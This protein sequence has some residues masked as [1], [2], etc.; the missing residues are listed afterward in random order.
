MIPT[1]EDVLA[2]TKAL[3]PPRLP[4]LRFAL[5]E[6]EHLAVDPFEVPPA[7]FY[8]LLRNRVFSSDIAVIRVVRCAAEALD[9]V[10]AA[11]D[12]TLLGWAV[13]IVEGGLTLDRLKEHFGQESFPLGE[14][15]S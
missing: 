7:L 9:L 11:D 3:A 13:H 8:A 10:V 4:A 2:W 15:L 6:A 14:I 1:T 12:A 5:R